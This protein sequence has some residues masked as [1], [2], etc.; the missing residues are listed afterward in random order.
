MARPRLLLL[1]EPSLGLAPLVIKDLFER[2]AELNRSLGTTMLIVEQNA[3]VALAIAQRAYVL[4]TGQ[5][6][7]EGP[8]EDLRHNDAVRRAYLGF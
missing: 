4:E 3:N 5:I 8:A 2:F 6:V 1:D 7:L